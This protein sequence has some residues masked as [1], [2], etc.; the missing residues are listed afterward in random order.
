MTGTLEAPRLRQEAPPRAS[1]PTLT[2]VELRKMYDTRAGMWLLM[3]IVAVA[4][5]RQI[6]SLFV[7]EPETRTF[8]DLFSASM[9][10]VSLLLPVVGTLAVTSEWSQR[11]AQVTFT[12][13]PHRSR[14]VA[15]KLAA[16]VVLTTAI[17]ALCLASAAVVNVLGTVL[18]DSDG[19]WHVTATGIAY[20][21][22][23]QLICV[24]S[25]MGLGMLLLNSAAAI[26]LYYV[27][28]TVWSLLA[29]LISAVRGPAQWLDLTITSVP[30][31]NDEM[32]GGTW[33]RLGTSILLWG[34][35]PLV[36][37]ML[38]LLRSEVK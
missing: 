9:L 25:G 15:A 21:L 3:I 4:I 18:V 37:G 14:I 17:V 19:S 10:P 7:G 20:G 1:L 31:I 34:V 8:A 5:L 35:A 26:V 28:P 30:L 27:L 36:L 33:A 12:L 16:A 13:V 38:R 6:L 22:L 11:T 2:A 32:T 24:L 29:N 23:Y